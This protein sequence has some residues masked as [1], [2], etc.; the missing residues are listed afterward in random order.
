MYYLHFAYPHVFYIF[1]PI[2]IAL[3]IYRWN[4]YRPPIYVYP[5]TSQIKNTAH[6]NKSYHKI[7]LFALRST[8]LL[9][10]IFLIARPQWVDARSRVN[11]DGVD[12][13]ITLDVSGS[14]QIF[15]DMNDRRPRI[16]VAKQEAVRFVRKRT[17]D[18][19]GVVIFA[20]DAIS[21]CPLTLDKSILT[22]V[23]KKTQLGFINPSG[24]SLGTGIATAINKLKNS[25]A[26]SKIIILLTDGQP[27]PN[28][29]KVPV[30]TSLKLAKQFGIKIYTI[31]IGN[32]KGAYVNSAFGFVEKIPDSVDENLL[33]KIARET[34]G[35]FFRANNSQDMKKI[36]D[37][38]DKLEK[39]KYETNLFSRYYEAFATFVWLIV[40]LFALELFLTLFIWRG[41]S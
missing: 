22:D 35:K 29:E 28:T 37:T 12:I 6:A 4:F 15:D 33:K 31:G 9:S 2:W 26:K 11:V 32:K 41:I 24:T 23:I 40:F 21:R 34:N 20:A 25:K 17:D 1:I 3:N 19:I 10:L 36:Y 14:M 16:D 13:I 38:I 5:L 27:T 8:L 30:E 39:T 7:V 18:P